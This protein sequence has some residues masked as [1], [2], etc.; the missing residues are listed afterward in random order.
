MTDVVALEL[1]SRAVAFAQTFQDSLDIRKC[2]AKNPVT[3][4]LEERPLPLVLEMRIAA[5]HRVHAEIHR[6]H[7]ERA[8]F[9]RDA[10]R[11]GEPIIQ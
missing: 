1:E 5:D 8:E 11:G 10:Q 3:R 4:G 6:T 9:R 2:V 7:V